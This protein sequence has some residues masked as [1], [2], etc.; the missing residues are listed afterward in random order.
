[1]QEGPFFRYEYSCLCAF[2]TARLNLDSNFLLLIFTEFVGLQNHAFFKKF[3]S[4][5]SKV[6]L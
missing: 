1:M 4:F 2:V 6:S 3:F 5:L